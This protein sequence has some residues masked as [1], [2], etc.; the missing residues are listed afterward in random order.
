M[1]KMRRLIPAIAMLL[2]SA[3]ML[4]TASFAW[5][6]M[7]TSATAEG[8]KIKAEASSSL[9]I[10]NATENFLNAFTM[11]DGSVEWEDAATALIPATHYVAPTGEGEDQVVTHP[12]AE[13]VTIGNSGLVSVDSTKVTAATGVYTGAYYVPAENVSN[14]DTYYVDYTVRIGASGA[15]IANQDLQATISLDGDLAYL[16]HNAVTIDF[17]V[18]ETK[19]T[20]PAY[21]Q[22]LNFE[23]IDAATNNSVVLTLASDVTIPQAL[24]AGEVETDDDG[25]VVSNGAAA[26]GD[27][28]TVTMRVYFDGAETN[29][30]NE[31]Y[32]RNALAVTNEI[33]FAVRFDAVDHQ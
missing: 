33:G 5:F 32:V 24:V 1:K 22:K 28:I 9:L 2:V 27:Y 12:L 15:A 6:T 25:A 31:I 8:M 18:S 4:S 14:G 16:L 7:S 17:L 11:A 10:T 20:A 26:L 3:V 19:G 23:T 21:Q 13:G 30:N 29:A